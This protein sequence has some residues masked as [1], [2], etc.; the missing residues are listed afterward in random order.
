MRLSL[1][2][3]Y[4]LFFSEVFYGQKLLPSF[5]S[6][7]MLAT[8]VKINLPI[9][10]T[11]SS[12]KFLIQIA[13]NDLVFFKPQNIYQ[14]ISTGKTI[15]NLSETT[16][17]IS[18][19][20]SLANMKRFIKGRIFNNSLN[21]LR[22]TTHIGETLIAIQEAKDGKDNWRPI[23]YWLNDRCGNSFG[24]IQLLLNNFI[25]F[26]IPRYYGSYKTKLR[27]RVLIGSKIYL[28]REW[29]GRIN[30][31]QFIKPKQAEDKNLKIFYS[32]LE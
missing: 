18:P 9:K 15:V 21:T 10:D 7:H 2:C 8:K 3:L 32:F 16:I 4:I 17:S 6:S 27:L 19:V 14:S 24:E 25:G 30:K 11:A 1:I 26:F 12:D 22:I 20:D 31:K 28:S 13:L 23:E 29:N 5:H